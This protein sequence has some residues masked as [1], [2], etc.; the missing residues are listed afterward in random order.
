[1]K[2]FEI[3]FYYLYLVSKYHYRPIH[4]AF[5][6]RNFIDPTGKFLHQQ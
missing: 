5:R 2:F 6:L 1:M 4:E 3:L